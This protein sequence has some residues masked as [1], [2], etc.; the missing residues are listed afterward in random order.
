MSDKTTAIAVVPPAHTD[1]ELVTAS[2]HEP[3]HT[4]E[5]LNDADRKAYIKGRTSLYQA[6]NRAW[7][8]WGRTPTA[9]E[10]R[11]EI[12]EGGNATTDEVKARIKELQASDAKLQAARQ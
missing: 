12:L 1:A 9:L 2:T 10:V 3:V 11:A 8:R 6:G 7:A 5:A 4:A